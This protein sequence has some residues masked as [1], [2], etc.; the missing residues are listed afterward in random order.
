MLDMLSLDL[1]SLSIAVGLAVS[2]VFSETLGRGAGGL[3]VPGYVAFYLTRPEAIAITLG[4]ALVTYAIVYYLSQV[5]IVYGRRRTVLMLLVGFLLGMVTRTVLGLTLSEPN[6]AY[7]VIGYIIP[8]LLAIWFDRQGLFE[9]L[10]TMLTAAAVV[11]LVLVLVASQQ[12]LETET[13]RIERERE[14]EL[15]RPFR[16]E[17]AEQGE[18]RDQ[19]ATI[20]P[21]E[22]NG[23]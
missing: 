5:L 11:R 20:T 6:P 8:G 22:Y 15:A 19:Q 7:T 2:L 12:V 23:M 17:A 3:V 9:T 4:I 13:A 10:T 16:V 21:V 1:L 18:V 14:I